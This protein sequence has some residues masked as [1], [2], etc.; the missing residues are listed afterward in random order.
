[1]T[2]RWLVV[3]TLTELTGKPYLSYSSY[4]T[5]LEC[6]EEYRLTRIEK[7][8][9]A[10]A[11]WF[12]GGSAVHYGCEVYDL[13]ILAG[14]PHAEAL[15]EAIRGFHDSFSDELNKAQEH[16]P[17]GA[18]W[19]AA[20]RAT[21]QWPNKEDAAWWR[22]N[23][24]EQVQG[25]AAWRQDHPEWGIWIAPN[26]EPAIELALTVDMGDG[27][28]THGYLDRILVHTVSGEMT[29]VDLKSG[30]RVPADITQL[31][32][33]ATGVERMFGTRPRTGRYFMTRTS[34]L[35][36]PTDLSRFNEPLLK[37]WLGAAKNGIESGAF[38]PKVSFKCGTC[39]VRD[40]CYVQNSDVP[41][42]EFLS[43]ANV[44]MTP[45]VK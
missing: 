28:M 14:L 1:M 17:E 33:Y 29:V 8:P 9:E 3:P 18:V 42:P 11:Y 5:Y 22:L 20:G 7:M 26:G 39:S 40:Y 19:R 27:V 30:S 32:L 36:S 12:P 31:A 43:T 34:E 45:E 23:G 38:L 4:S 41:L 16:A 35:T 24:P 6:G 15:E 21:K 10:P 37:L 25:Y 13:K 44:N 2:H